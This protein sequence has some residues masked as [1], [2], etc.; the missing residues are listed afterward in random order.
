MGFDFATPKGEFSAEDLQRCSAPTLT[1]KFQALLNSPLHDVAIR[2]RFLRSV[3]G[4]VPSDRC[5][6]RRH[7][8]VTCQP[9][10]RALDYVGGIIVDETASPTGSWQSAA[11]RQGVDRRIGLAQLFDPDHHVAKMPEYWP[12][13]MEIGQNSAP[14]LVMANSGTRAASSWPVQCRGRGQDQI[15]E[16]AGIAPDQRLV[17]ETARCVCG[18]IS[19]K[20]AARV[21]LEV[22]FRG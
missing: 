6:V 22:P 20:G 14:K 12:A 16:M 4:R 3:Q 5:A 8:E 17:R 1:R 18:R 9:Q 15:V 19:A 21:V 11:A 2:R 10:S 7:R 13:G